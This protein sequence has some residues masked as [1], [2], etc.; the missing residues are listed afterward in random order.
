MQQVAV[1]CQS[2]KLHGNVAWRAETLQA[3]SGHPGRVYEQSVQSVVE[4]IEEF[5]S[6]L[7]LPIITIGLINFIKIMCVLRLYR[8]HQLKKSFFKN[9]FLLFFLLFLVLIVRCVT[10]KTCF[11]FST[12]IKFII[13]VR[14]QFWEHFLTFSIDGNFLLV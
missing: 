14:Y 3:C 6:Y 9:N 5:F 11:F 8:I 10:P 13:M 7:F 12:R 4:A 2:K 1:R